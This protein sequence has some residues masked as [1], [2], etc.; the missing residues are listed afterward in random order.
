MAKDAAKGIINR[1]QK[2][3]SKIIAAS[4]SKLSSQKEE[5][6]WSPEE[7]KV[8]RCLCFFLLFCRC[9]PFFFYVQMLEGLVGENRRKMK[10]R[11]RKK[12]KTRA[13]APDT[14]TALDTTTALDTATAPDTATALDP[15]VGTGTFFL[16][17]KMYCFSDDIGY[18]CL[19][20]SR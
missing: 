8:D 16:P 14:A 15:D 2:E 12:Q 6:T 10:K 20:A 1:Q 9:Q 13:K 5:G 3:E 19:F 18:M 4:M 17:Y 11:L 7:L